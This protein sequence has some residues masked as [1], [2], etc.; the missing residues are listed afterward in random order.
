[1]K[2]LRWRFVLITAVTLVAAYLVSPSIIYFSAPKEIRNSDEEMQKRI[3]DWLPQKHVSLG[4]DLQGGVQLVLGVNTDSAIEN[5]LTR[6]GTEV[7]RWSDDNSI[8]VAKAYVLVGK[9]QLRVELKEGVD[10]GA[11]RDKF[12][13]EFPGFAQAAKTDRTIDYVYDEDQLKR[14]KA[15]AIEQAEKVVRNRVD[16]WGVAEPS[17]SRRQADN[18][19]LV[20][21]PGFKDPS[22]AKELL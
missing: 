9:G 16:K 1:M 10:F 11:F 22:K 21:L 4:L 8:G 15:S 19:I 5:K 17:I 6:V 14:I 3:P 13:V 7:Q 2:Q 12:R 20:Q 18:S